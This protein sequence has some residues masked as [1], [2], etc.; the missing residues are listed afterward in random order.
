VNAP[1]RT[2]SGVVGEDSLDASIR[3]IQINSALTAQPDA[4]AVPLI[5]LEVAVKYKGAR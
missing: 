2:G 1:A 5:V 3:A 4:V